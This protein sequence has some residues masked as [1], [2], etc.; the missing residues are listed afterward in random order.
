MDIEKLKQENAQLRQ[1]IYNLQQQ[2]AIYQ[3]Q[4]KRQWH[5]NQ[6]YLPSHEDDRDE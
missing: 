2:L 5:Y 3:Q 6:D 1:Q 4:Y